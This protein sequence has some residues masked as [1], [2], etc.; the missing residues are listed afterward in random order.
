MNDTSIKSIIGKVDNIF[1]S[2]AFFAMMNDQSCDCDEI[3]IKSNGNYI[4]LI[5]EV[6][7]EDGYIVLKCETS[8]DN[9]KY[10]YEVDLN[11]LIFTFDKCIYLTNGVIEGLRF[12][13]DGVFLFIFASEHNLV[14]TM[15]KLD[16]FEEI[17]MHYPENEAVL[18]IR[19]RILDTIS[20]ID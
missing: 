13:S 11:G 8:H 5:S 9:N 4:R 17:D 20:E 7:G 1:I 19:E 6:V 10:T 3:I 16:L 18:V 14:L 2:N 15:S 12:T